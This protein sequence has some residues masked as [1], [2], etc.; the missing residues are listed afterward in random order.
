MYKFTNVDEE[1]LESWTLSV[2]NISDFV[3]KGFKFSILK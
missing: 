1:P 3:L 2:G